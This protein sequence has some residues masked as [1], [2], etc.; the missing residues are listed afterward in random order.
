MDVGAAL[1][2]RRGRFHSQSGASVEAYDFVEVTANVER[3]DASNPFTDATLGGSFSKAGATE[4]ATAKVSAIR[5][6]AASSCS[7]QLAV[8]AR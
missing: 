3:P 8:I 6:M 1:L 7:L 5:R 2:G 4:P